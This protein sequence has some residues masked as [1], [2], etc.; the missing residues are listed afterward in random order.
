MWENWEPLTTIMKHRYLYLF[1]AIMVFIRNTINYMVNVHFQ[2]MNYFTLDLTKNRKMWGWWNVIVFLFDLNLIAGK[3]I[4]IHS[5]YSLFGRFMFWTVNSNNLWAMGPGKK[6]MFQFLW[7]L[8]GTNM[9]TNF[10]EPIDIIWQ[11]IL[12]KTVLIY[13]YLHSEWVIEINTYS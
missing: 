3:K 4:Y 9:N 7:K 12:M 8:N 5:V 10:E 13:Y 6:Q 2:P 1:L 11:V